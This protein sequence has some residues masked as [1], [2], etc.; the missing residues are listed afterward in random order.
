[1]K[2][3][4]YIFPRCSSEPVNES[5]SNFRKHAPYSLSLNTFCQVRTGKTP[6]NKALTNFVWKGYNNCIMK[7]KTINISL[8]EKLYAEAKK[9]QGQYH[10]SSVSE[11]IRDALRWWL[12][13]R[14]TRNGFTPEF[15]REVLQAE[16]EPMKNA[17][18]WDGKGSFVDFVLKHKPLY[19]G[20]GQ[21]RRSLSKKPRVFGH[22]DPDTWEQSGRLR[23]LVP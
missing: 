21:K 8:P 15:E 20:K 7:N 11:L 9:H 13:P 1:M 14:L 18:E 3:R 5:I 2:R 17:V 4:S 6:L 12:N 16:K 22:A 10:Y 19:H 23:P